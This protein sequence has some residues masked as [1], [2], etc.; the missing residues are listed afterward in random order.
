MLL[1]TVSNEL[2]A[3]DLWKGVNRFGFVRSSE[4]LVLSGRGGETVSRRERVRL[5][6]V[7]DLN[8]S[9]SSPPS[10]EDFRFI[11]AIGSS[12]SNAGVATSG[13]SLSSSSLF[14]A[15]ADIRCEA[16]S[17]A[18]MGERRGPPMADSFAFFSRPVGE[19]MGALSSA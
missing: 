10:S 18:R 6:L 3:E 13:G 19:S 5:L 4:P 12:R 17:G 8:R 15:A 2:D 11:P 14:L 9:P 7:D 16:V 1:L